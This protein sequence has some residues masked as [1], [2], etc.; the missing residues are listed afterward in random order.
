M[1]PEGE[2]TY[3]QLIKCGYQLPA[4]MSRE[5]EVTGSDIGIFSAL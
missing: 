2:K 3:F 1:E 5:I 4:V